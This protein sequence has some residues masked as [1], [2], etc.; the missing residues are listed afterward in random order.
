[1]HVRLST[2]PS[3]PLPPGA[4]EKALLIV[5]NRDVDGGTF[6]SALSEELTPR[7][8]ALGGG[9]SSQAELE[10]VV[11][12]QNLTKGTAVFLTWTLPADLQVS[13]ACCGCL[14]WTPWQLEDM[15]TCVG[16]YGLMT[17]AMCVSVCSNLP[18]FHRSWFQSTSPIIAAGN[19]SIC[20][21]TERIV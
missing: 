18:G 19:C 9:Q 21:F 10:A 14:R 4:G 20:S 2:S 7:L 5:L 8:A 15:L 3:F 6:V 17:E 12:A 13:T 16:S 11:K 1:M